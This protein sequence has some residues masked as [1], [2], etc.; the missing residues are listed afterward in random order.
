MDALFD[1][2]SVPEC[3]EDI[4]MDEVERCR[5]CTFA[6]QECCDGY[7]GNQAIIWNPGDITSRMPV[8]AER[9][10]VSWISTLDNDSVLVADNA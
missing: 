10:T 7:W 1:P 6:G 3:G 5:E 9:S 2:M 8:S 4:G